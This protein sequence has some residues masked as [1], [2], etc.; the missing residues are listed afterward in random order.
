MDR[1]VALDRLAFL[2]QAWDQIEPS[3]ILRDQAAKVLDTYPL[4]AADSLQLAAALVWCRN[5]PTGRTFLCADTRLCEAATQ[6][7]FTVLSP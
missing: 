5:R 4:C 2:Q 1:R 3:D 6:A 7:G